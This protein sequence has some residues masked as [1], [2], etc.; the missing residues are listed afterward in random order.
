MG[1]LCQRPDR[2]IAFLCRFDELGDPYTHNTGPVMLDI[3]FIGLGVA[4][5]AVCL[6]YVRLCEWL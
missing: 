6:A 4:G 5:F 2:G 3:V 1:F